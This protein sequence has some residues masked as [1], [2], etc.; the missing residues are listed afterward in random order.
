MI[1]NEENDW[2]FNEEGPVGCVCRDE[3]EQALNELK[4][5]KAPGT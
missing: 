1:L 5:G 2:G 3:A 4:T